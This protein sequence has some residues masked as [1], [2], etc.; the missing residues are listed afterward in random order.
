MAISPCPSHTCP[1]RPFPVVP[2]KNP[3]LLPALPTHHT[4]SLSLPLAV[5]FAWKSLCSAHTR[6]RSPV[7]SA[8]PGQQ[9]SPWGPSVFICTPVTA[10]I[11]TGR[12]LFILRLRQQQGDPGGWKQSP[13]CPEEQVRAPGSQAARPAL[14]PGLACGEGTCRT[15][16]P[17][18]YRPSGQKRVAQ[19]GLTERPLE[20]RLNRRSAPRILALGA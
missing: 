16:P 17:G 18:R 8:S 1:T 20:G 10:S 7:N 15:F 11:V 2:A 13:G 9:P 14:W 3:G 19:R 5:P 12:P 4:S 6:V